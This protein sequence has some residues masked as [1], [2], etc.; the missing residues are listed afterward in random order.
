[1]V[2]GSDDDTAQDDLLHI[3]DFL[4]QGEVST[5]GGCK[6]M[7]L[8]IPSLRVRTGDVTALIG[9][10]GCGKSV[11]ISLLMGYPSFGLGGQ[12][13]FAVFNMLGEE[14]KPMAFRSVAMVTE[15]RRRLHRIGGIFFLPQF[16]PVAKTLRI[17]TGDAML[18]VVMALTPPR[19]ALRNTAA[20]CLKNA[21]EKH[22]L[23][24]LGG[25]KL[26]DLSGGE[27]R[28]AELLA[29]LVAMKVS[30]LPGL[31]VLDEPTTGFDPANA[32]GFIRDVRAM[33]DELREQNIPSAALLSTHE[34]KSLDDQVR[35]RR[36]IDRVCIVHR[37]QDG[38]NPDTCTVIFDGAPDCVWKHFFKER[39]AMNFAENGDQLLNQLK[40]RRAAEWVDAF[41]E[42]LGKG[43][44]HVP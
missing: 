18:Q 32:Q 20:K 9:G 12:A 26:K 1:M 24:D 5:D 31:L 4:L 42:S 28:R 37:D 40:L 38:A 14:M 27:R 19:C 34:M 30:R 10:S 15:W 36:V 23:G 29:R 43:T 22:G 7:A 6:T 25:K 44:S 17:S 35:G 41:N 16:F 11:L 3:E 8:R 21:F 13:A 39:S 2:I 33:I